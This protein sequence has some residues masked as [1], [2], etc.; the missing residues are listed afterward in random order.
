MFP[1]HIA[2]SL[3]LFQIQS[4]VYINFFPPTLQFG[5]LGPATHVRFNSPHSSCSIEMLPFLFYIRFFSLC[6]SIPDSRAPISWHWLW[7]K[8]LQWRY[9]RAPAANEKAAARIQND[10]VPRATSDVQR[11][12]RSGLPVYQVTWKEADLAYEVKD[13]GMFCT[14]ETLFSVHLRG[15]YC[16]YQTVDV[17]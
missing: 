11:S 9:P 14:G 15:R 6:I 8:H 1:S 7:R 5:G 13:T 2:K 10:F 12:S 16:L 4:L 3:D 17:F